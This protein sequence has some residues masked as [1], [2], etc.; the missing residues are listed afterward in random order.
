MAAALLQQI[1]QQN[2][3]LIQ[4]LVD[5]QRHQ[6][7]N[8]AT[9]NNLLPEELSIAKDEEAIIFSSSTSQ[10]LSHQTEKVLNSNVFKVSILI[11]LY[12]LKTYKNVEIF[13]SS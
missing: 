8:L 10:N 3:S 1:Q 5:Q 7:Q 6:Q 12:F 13:K 9:S 4:N 11:I 2:P